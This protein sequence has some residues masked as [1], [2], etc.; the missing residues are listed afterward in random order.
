MTLP[1]DEQFR[2]LGRI[3]DSELVLHTTRDVSAV[4]LAKGEVQLEGTE[5]GA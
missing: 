2:D 1:I 4:V 3:I 5:S